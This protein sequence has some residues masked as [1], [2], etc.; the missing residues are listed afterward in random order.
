VKAIVWT[1]YGPPDVLQLREVAKPA[2]KDDEVLIKIHAT[3]A[4]AGDSELRSLKTPIIYRLPM[5]IYVGWSKPTRITILGQ[6]LAGEIEAVGKDVKRFKEGD[7]VF[8]PPG[9]GMG[10]YAE[11]ICLPEDGFLAMKPANMSY[12]EA[13]TLSIGGNEALYFMRK[14]NI[15]SGDKVLIVGAGGSIGT[16]AIQLAKY[17]GAEVTGVDRT[18]KLDFMRSIGA[19]WVVDYTQEDFTKRGQTYDVIFDVIGKSP[20][21]GSIRSLKHNGRYL[22]GNPG[23]SEMVRAPWTS[24]ISGKNVYTGT[25]SNNTEDLVF[26]K[27][28]IMAGKIRSII[29]RTYTLEQMVEAHRYVESGQKKGHVVITVDHNNKS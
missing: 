1:N 29:D 27:E 18:E 20:F 17:Y 5:R 6:E 16:F 8:G 4:F 21:S 7:Q 10:A 28:L 24:W 9:F 3:T 13:A 23:L 19:D 15:Q 12:V 22:I 2:P 25:A 11:Y 14:A 26:L